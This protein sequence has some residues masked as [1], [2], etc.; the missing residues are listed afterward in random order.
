MPTRPLLP[1]VNS[2]H[3]KT[4]DQRDLREGERQ[5]G[6]IDARQAHA[7]PAIDDGEQAGGERRQHQRQLHRQA[8]LLEQQRAGIGAEA[9]IGGVAER[10]HAGRAHDEMQADRE[11]REAGDVG[12]QNG[13]VAVGKQRHDQE[14]REPGRDRPAARRCERRRRL[15]GGARH[16]RRLAEQAVGPHHQHQPHDHEL[17]DEGELGDAEA[18]AER[19]GHADQDGG[20]ERA[21]QAAQAADHGDDEGVGDDRQV[22]V[23]IGGLARDLQRAAQPRQHRADEEHRGEQL[24]LVDAQRADHLA[25]LSRGA[26]QRAPARAGEQQP[27]QAEHHRADHDQQQ[28][29]DRDALAQDLD[30]HGEAGRA[31]TDQILR[32]PGEQRHVL[33]HQDD[34][35]GGEQLE[36]LGR[37]VDAAQD[38]E[39]DHDADQ[40]DR[41]RRQ[42]HRAPE[43]ERRAAQRLDQ[44]VGAV[45]PQHVERAVREIDDPRHAEDQRQAGRHQEQRRGSGQPVQELD[46]DGGEGHA[47]CGAKTAIAERSEGSFLSPQGIPALRSG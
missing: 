22:E 20:E 18:D 29:V 14:Q 10:H 4:I 9:E 16:G 32:T 3:W 30:R 31:R 17:D 27:E 38:E 11:Q 2:S 1:E 8:G 40:P 46:D 37:A 36:E 21:A 41:E 42:D 45:E 44:A 34:G 15:A 24:G 19:L 12:Q 35:E 47:V 26:H 6:E 43:A 33:D 5:H 7:E 13:D 25:V 28:V 39:L 23:E